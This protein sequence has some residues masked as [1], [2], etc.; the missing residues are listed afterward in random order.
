MGADSLLSHGGEEKCTLS[1]TKT[2]PYGFF[3]KYF[4]KTR[5]FLSKST[6]NGQ[7]IR[8]KCEAVTLI[9]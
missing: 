6:L 4:I 8:Q 7:L 1:V 5:T 3:K 9:S 2:H